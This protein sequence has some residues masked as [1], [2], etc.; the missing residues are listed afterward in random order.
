MC[1]S[2]RSTPAI[3]RKP[4]GGFSMRAE[5]QFITAEFMMAEFITVQASACVVDGL[6]WTVAPRG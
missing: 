4:C 2:S 6:S 3:W 5:P 1:W